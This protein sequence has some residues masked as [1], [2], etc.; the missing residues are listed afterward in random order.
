MIFHPVDARTLE[1]RAAWLKL[2]LG[3]PTASCFDKILTPAKLELSKQ[4]MPYML[5]LLEEWITGEEIDNPQSDWMTRGIEDED[6]AVSSYESIYDVETE[7]GGFATTDDGMIGA[8]ADRLVDGRKRGLEIKTGAIRTMAGY[9]LNGGL[10][11]D[12]LLQ[13]Q[14]QIMVYELDSVEVFGYNRVIIPKPVRVYR[15][16]KVI[17]IMCPVLNTFVEKMLEARL[18]LE[19][20]FGPFTRPTVEQVDHA[21]DYL[22]DEDATAIWEESQR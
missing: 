22:T 5:Q 20:E 17:G 2:R 9:F 1:G 12:H 13:V 18:K 4:A 8:S 10:A 21:K 15:D 7:P 16:D 3:I 19:R 11:E 14:G 6:L